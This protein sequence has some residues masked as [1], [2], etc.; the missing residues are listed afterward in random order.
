[1]RDRVQ[2][3]DIRKELGVNSIKEKVRTMRLRW[4]GHTQRMEDNNEVRAF[5]DMVVPAKRPRGR[6]TGRW[7]DCFRRDVQEQPITPEGAQE[8][9]FWR[10]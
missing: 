3:I 4:H 5:V 10:S 6:S 9:K 2:S 1:M 8:R 7:M